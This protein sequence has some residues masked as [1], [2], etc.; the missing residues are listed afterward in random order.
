MTVTDT[1]PA[2]LTPAIAPVAARA[3]GPHIVHGYRC[4]HCRHQWATA[5]LATAYP[6]RD[7][8]QDAA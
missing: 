8:H 5:R 4:P 1:C 6:A 3:R 7:Y 2:C